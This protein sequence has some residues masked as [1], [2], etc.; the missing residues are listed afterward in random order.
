MEAV[1]C[2]VFKLRTNVSY[3]NYWLVSLIS[4]GLG[5]NDLCLWS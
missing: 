3:Y 1:E 2:S 4:L 5:V